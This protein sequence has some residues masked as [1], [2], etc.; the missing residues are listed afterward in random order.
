MEEVRREGGMEGGRE[1][2]REGKEGEGSFH[3]NFYPPTQKKK[4]YQT[5]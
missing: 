5:S 1:E 4:L 2:G 3:M